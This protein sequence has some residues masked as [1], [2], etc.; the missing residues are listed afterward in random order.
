MSIRYK[1]IDDGELAARDAPGLPV[2]ARFTIKYSGSK[3]DVV[4]SVLRTADSEWV[5]WREFAG[6]ASVH[7]RDDGLFDAGQE[8]HSPQETLH[9][10]IYTRLGP[11]SLD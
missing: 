5:A 11:F 7:R 9:D 6:Q 2:G 4:V 10:A 3:R 1:T 8:G